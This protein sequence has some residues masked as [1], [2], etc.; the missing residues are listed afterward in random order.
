MWPFGTTGSDTQKQHLRTGVGFV[1]RPPGCPVSSRVLKAFG[2][3]IPPPR[4]GRPRRVVFKLVAGTEGLSALQRRQL[5]A[6]PRTGSPLQCSEDRCPSIPGVVHEC[7]LTRAAVR[8]APGHNLPPRFP[9]CSG[10]KTHTGIPQP[11][12]NLVPLPS[13]CVNFSQGPHLS[14]PRNSYLCTAGKN[15][16]LISLFYKFPKTQSLKMDFSSLYLAAKHG[17]I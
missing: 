16:W 13:A 14:D 1:L 10:L 15:L 2:R 12:S 5:V 6:S 3:P 8:P 9:W 4:E 11:G 17:L 7:H